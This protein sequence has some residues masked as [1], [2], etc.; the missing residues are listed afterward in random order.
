MVQ[1]SLGLVDSK[2]KCKAS[3]HP[4]NTE[5]IFHIFFKKKLIIQDKYATFIGTCTSL[6]STSTELSI[7]QQ[8]VFQ[9]GI[10]MGWNNKH[11]LKARDL[12]DK[13]FG[14]LITGLRKA[15]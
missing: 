6:L 15:A 5:T 10:L 1:K 3:V 14:R 11:L 7:L 2:A 9:K 12:F 4:T 13:D 8:F